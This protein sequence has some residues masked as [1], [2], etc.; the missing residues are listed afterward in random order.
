MPQRKRQASRRSR[1]RSGKTTKAIACGKVRYPDHAGAVKALHTIT[2]K[3]ERRDVT[4]ARAYECG[5]C[6]GWHLTSR[7]DQ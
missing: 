7:A 3:G 1:P 4:P 2:T 6:N 5:R